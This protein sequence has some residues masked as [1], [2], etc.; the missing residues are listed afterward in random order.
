LQGRRPLRPRL[1]ERKWSPE[2]ASVT[3]PIFPHP[4]EFIHEIGGN[5]VPQENQY[6]PKRFFI[7]YFN[8][9]WFL[10]GG[11]GTALR[12]NTQIIHN[13]QN[14]STQNYTNHKDT[15]QTMNTMQIKKIKSKKSK[16][17]RVTGLGGL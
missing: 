4:A 9:K 5:Y 12:H 14:N 1:G 3:Q 7:I 2:P 10:R 11:S 17:I 8:C 6:T 16:A 13:I 15:L